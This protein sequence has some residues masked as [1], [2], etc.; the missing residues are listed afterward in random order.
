MNSVSKTCLGALCLCTLLHAP[1]TAQIV[2]RLSLDQSI[3]VAIS[4]G[5]VA[6]D[7][8]A[9]YL[10]ARDRATS[11]Q[12]ALWTSVSLFVTAPDYSQSLTQ[13]FN[14]STGNYEYY[15]LQTTNYQGA[16]TISQPLTLTGGTLRFSQS[17]LGRAQTSGLTGSNNA[18]NDYF[19]DFAF[20]LRQPLLT[21]NQHRMNAQRA[22]IAFEQA[23]T[24]FLNAQLDLVYRVTESF[25]TLF[26]QT[27]RLEI[28]K[29]QVKQ[30]E[31]SYNAAQSKFNGG[32]IPEVEVLQSDVDLASSRN[33]SLSTE[34][35]L[36]QAKNEFRLL[37]GIAPEEDVQPVAE[38]TYQPVSLDSGRAVTAALQYRS[39]AL[40]AD[41]DIQLREL[42]VS[43][44]KAQNNFRLDLTARYGGNKTDTVFRDIFHDLNRSRSAS[45]TLS[46]PIFDWG[47][48]GLNVEAAEVELNNATVQREYTRQQVRQETMDLLNRIRVAQSRIEVL[49]KSVKVAQ[50]SYDISLQRF[51]NGTINRNDLAQAQQRLTGA[52]LNS[53]S[54]LV[55]YR[56]GVAD[57]IRKTHWD[58]EKNAPVEP[59]IHIRE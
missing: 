9:R 5:L 1:A 28:V 16:L 40:R 27:Q 6:S 4:K 38:L 45:L 35:E 18:I 43:S 30:N 52:K 12:R 39:E 37:L 20:E 46:I 50:Q 22:D 32:L 31:E 2:H 10:A 51:R 26:Q 56:L 23:E 21:T 55:D 17:V 14:P 19:G 33:D 49:Q 53:L 42:D 25:Y 36:S 8:E 29:E 11:A 24:D 54:A 13:Q 57:L 15:Q 7:V 48:N 41:R 58:F 34:R 47:R 3:A 44:A 59:I